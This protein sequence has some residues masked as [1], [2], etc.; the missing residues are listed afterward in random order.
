MTVRADAVRNRERILAAAV[1][2]FT[3]D[4]S[5]ASTEA[6]AAEAGVGI[7][8]V[9]RHFPSKAELVEATLA[10]HLS[11]MGAFARGLVDDPDPGAALAR[12]V[13]YFADRAAVTDALIEAIELRGGNATAAKGSQRGRVRRIVATLLRRAQQAGEVRGDLTVDDLL[14]LL[15]GTARAVQ[16]AGSRRGN[17]A[18]VVRTIL[19]GLRAE[20]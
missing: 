19:A 14:A 8:T 5:S 12:F 7:A 10:E 11:A 16:H 4:G 2:V 20:P 3:R 17:P 13:A 15:V 1:T 6:V 9:F 18:R